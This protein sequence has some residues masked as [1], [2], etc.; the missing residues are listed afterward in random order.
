MMCYT[1]Y[2]DD[3]KTAISIPDTLFERGERAASRLGLNRSELYSHALEAFLAAEGPDPVTESLNA[4][5]DVLGIHSSSTVFTAE[6]GR[7]LVDRGDWE[8]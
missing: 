6:A 4:L 7:Q 1:R 5:V 8:W 3:V 2:T